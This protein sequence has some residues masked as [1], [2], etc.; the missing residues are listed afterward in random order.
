[1]AKH[2]VFTRFLR[3]LEPDGP[4]EREG[5]FPEVWT[6]LRLLLVR[7]LKRRSLWSL[8]PAYLGIHGSTTWADPEAVEELLADCF[9]FVFAERF[10]SLQAQLSHKPDV[11]GLVLRNVRNFLHETQKRH[12]PIGFRVFTVLRNGVRSLLSA[13]EL[14]VIDGNPAVGRDTVLAFGLEAS[15]EEAARAEELRPHL[16][17]WNDDLL[18]G[19]ITARGWDVRHVTARLESH[20]HDLAS[21]GVV[22]FRFQ[23]LIDT[24]RQD[25]RSRWRAVW[26]HTP[27]G[28]PP[29]LEEEGFGAVA[30]LVELSEGD[31]RESLH[32]LLACLE[33][34]I[35]RVAEPRAHARNYLRRLLSFLANHAADSPDERGAPGAGLPSHRQLAKLLAIPRERLPDL[36]RTLLELAAACRRKVSG[37]ESP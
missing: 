26:L 5:D 34:S 8:S 6:A 15:S 35:E 7:E 22:A 36:F 9:V 20:L 24:L 19:L 30:R 13:G 32:R 37:K 21:A 11:E 28:I 25:A 3:N 23:D 2:S 1:M 27:E 31:E 29:Q 33:R 4:L 12:D 10:R 18:P 14:Q 16:L 17:G